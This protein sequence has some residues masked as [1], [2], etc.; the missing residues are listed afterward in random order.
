MKDK[1]LMAIFSEIHFDNEFIYFP[2]CIIKDKS[3]L[4]SLLNE[5]LVLEDNLVE[6]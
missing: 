6:P 4:E 2:K 1:V 5:N 3:M